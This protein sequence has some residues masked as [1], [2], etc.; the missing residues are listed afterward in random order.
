MGTGKLVLCCGS[1]E[2]EVCEA[3]RLSYVAILWIFGSPEKKNLG[4]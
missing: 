3:S 4:P 1:A 2:L